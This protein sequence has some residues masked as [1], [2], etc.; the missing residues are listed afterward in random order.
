M[1]KGDII[2]HYMCELL[3]EFC[4]DYMEELLPINRPQ[5]MDEN[6]RSKLREDLEEMLFRML[7]MLKKCDGDYNKTK[8]KQYK[9]TIRFMVLE[10]LSLKLRGDR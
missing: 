4:E 10:E 1:T 5:D 2:N 6:V 7:I 9:E 3:R 8:H